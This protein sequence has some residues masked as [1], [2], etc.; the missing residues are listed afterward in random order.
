M[1]DANTD[2]S[3]FMIGAVIIAGMIIAGATI[4]FKEQIFGAG[5]VL[6]KTFATLT[7]KA[8]TLV[9]GIDTALPGTG[10]MIMPV[11]NN[12]TKG[13]SALGL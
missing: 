7:G 12:V 10:G 1:L 3:Y 2:R 13:L 11:L 9:G 6:T 8:E 4:I 5:G